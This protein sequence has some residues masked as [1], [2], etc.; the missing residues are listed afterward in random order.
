MTTI[1]LKATFH[2]ILMSVLNSIPVALL[3]VCLLHMH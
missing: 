1:R 2:C 3:N